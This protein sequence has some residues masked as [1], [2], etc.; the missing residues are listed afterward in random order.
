MITDKNWKDFKSV[1]PKRLI[2]VF[3]N[4]YET[5]LE[6]IDRLKPHTILI[7]NISD[8]KFLNSINT[9]TSFITTT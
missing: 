2:Y 9:K 1:H 7:S 4:N 8:L 3:K 5:A 6:V